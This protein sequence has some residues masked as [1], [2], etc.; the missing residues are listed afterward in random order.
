MKPPPTLG[1]CS[2]WLYVVEESSW[3]SP[4]ILC[5]SGER[6]EPTRKNKVMLSSE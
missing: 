6:D 3:F 4:V 5:L 1:K 2:L